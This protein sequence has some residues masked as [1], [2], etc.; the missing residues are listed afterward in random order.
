M[1]QRKKGKDY[2]AT[3]GVAKDVSEDELKKAYKKMALKWHPDRNLD[4][5]VA[6]EARFKE[7]GEAYEVLSDPSKRQI[8]D[9][10]GEEGLK[11]GPPPQASSSDGFDGAAHFANGS[12]AGGFRGR[13]PG[14]FQPSRAED[15]FAQMFGGGSGGLGG[16]GGLGSMFGGMGGGMGGMPQQQQRQ[17]APPPMQYV[18]QWHGKLPSI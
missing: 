10:Y 6:A 16:M 2:Y 9:E 3:L 14:G 11:G 17:Q 8:Y 7:I 5:K 1:S 12:G 15:I 4:N 18:R 13:F